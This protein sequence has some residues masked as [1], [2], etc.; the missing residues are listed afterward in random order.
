MGRHFTLD[1]SEKQIAFWTRIFSLK[2]GRLA[3]PMNE[4]LKASG[5]DK[6]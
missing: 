3:A 6:T 2:K 5:G 1:Y 4:A